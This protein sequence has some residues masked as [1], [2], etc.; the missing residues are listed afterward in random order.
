MTEEKIVMKAIV[1]MDQPAET[2]AMELAPELPSSSR[3]VAE[4][5]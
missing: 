3:L 1:V 2:A 5:G 4:I